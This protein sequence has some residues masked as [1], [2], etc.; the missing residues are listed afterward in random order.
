MAQPKGFREFRF[1]WP[2]VLASAIGIGLGMSPLPFYTIGVF[3]IPLGEE[4]GWGIDRVMAALLVFTASAFVMSPIIGHIADRVGVRRVVLFSL[5]SFSL[6]MM[7]FAL[8]NGSFTLFLVLWGVLGV[9]GAGTLPITWTRAV[10][11]WFH[12]RRGLALGIALVATG[13]F[14][15]LAKLYAAAMVDAFGWRAAYVA[16]GALPL[17][18]AFPLAFLAFR[19]VDDPRAAARA[20]RLRKAVPIVEGRMTS[21]IPL[22]S[23]LRD[24]RF[25]L[26]AYVFLP[27]SFA[28]GGPIPNLEKMMLS[29][30]F[31]VD[32]AVVLASLI[33]FSVMAGRVVGGYLLD[34]L[35]APAVAAVIL[36]LPALSC[37][38]L[39]GA[40][41]S[42]L[43]AAFAIC[44]LGAAAGVEYDLI[45]YL[46]SRYFG[47]RSYAAIYGCLYAFFAAGAGFGPLVFGRIFVQ[48]GSYDPALLAAAVA[49]V[50]G[51]V[52]LLLLGPYREFDGDRRPGRAGDYVSST[53]PSTS[54]TSV[55]SGARRVSDSRPS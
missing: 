28:V 12:E 11:G 37:L 51:A 42:F 4:F 49:F 53:L 13:F 39:Q 19:S 55:P 15:S 41:H 3:A 21:G 17:F 16:V 27:V 6:S 54:S 5:V 24:W 18:I 33:G 47:M 25:W 1:G 26:L 48:V 50:A 43:S 40:D 44:L 23:A 8:N 38:M 35:W 9:F 32:D 45:A 22:A 34:R 10:T 36:S 31:T 14:G 52:P 30:G 46:V 20:A 2:V 7:A 29:K